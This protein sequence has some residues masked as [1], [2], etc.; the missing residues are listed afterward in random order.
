MFEED[1]EWGRTV[2][3]RLDSVHNLPAAEGRYHRTCYPEFFREAHSHTPGWPQT[4]EKSTAFERLCDHI[5]SSSE[6]QYSI[7][8]L[9]SMLCDFVSGG[10]S[11]RT[12]HLKRKLQD[13]YGNKVTITN[14][15][16]KPCIFTF[17]KHSHKILHNRWYTDSSYKVPIKPHTQ[18]PSKSLG[19]LTIKDPIE[20]E[21]AT[22]V[23]ECLDV[24]WISGHTIQATPHPSWAW[25]MQS[26]MQNTGTYDVSEITTLP[27]IKLDPSDCS[28][29]YTALCYARWGQALNWP[30][31]L[32]VLVASI[33]WCP[34]WVQANIT[35]Q[36]V[37]FKSFGS[38]YMPRIQWYKWYQ[39]M[40]T[41][42]HCEL[43]SWHSRL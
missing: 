22:T 43:I 32:F 16:G 9:E 3:G 30:V 23:A 11:Y 26:A 41:A 8:E 27:F 7:S 20:H 14:V 1:E 39:E 40:H 42:V 28:T 4:H 25:F 5:D 37:D 13:H 10:D 29:I 21:V 36:E 6:Y 38:P 2:L 33:C 19:K 34:W 15:P 24:L 17:H 18:P 35:C 12:K 31:W